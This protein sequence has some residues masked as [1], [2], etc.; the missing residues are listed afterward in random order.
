MFRDEFP[1]ESPSGKGLEDYILPIRGRVEIEKK[2][3]FWVAVEDCT[4][5]Y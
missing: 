4:H 5:S 2:G 3:T 1:V